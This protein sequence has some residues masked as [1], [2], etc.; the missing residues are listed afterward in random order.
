VSAEAAK[1]IAKFPEGVL[2]GR[3]AAGFP[4]SVRQLALPYDAAS[5]EMK[6]VVPEGL[7]L[8]EGL[9]TLLCHFH[10]EQM[11]GLKAILVKGRVARR[12]GGWV[13]ITT[14]FT[15]PSTWEMIKGTRVA[16]KSYLAKRGLPVPQVNFAAIEKLW[17]RARQI[18][19]P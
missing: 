5:G 18:R 14:A 10:N 6:L 4:L 8:Q 11:W 3:D 2:N 13:F 12:N 16:M 17:E 1:W 9:A 7:G 19:D 15:P